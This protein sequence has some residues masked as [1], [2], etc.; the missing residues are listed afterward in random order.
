MDSE[1]A[2]QSA[3]SLQTEIQYLRRPS[4][5]A[6]A[7][8]MCACGPTGR[9]RGHRPVEVSGVQNI[10]QSAELGIFLHASG[11]RSGYLGLE[12]EIR[13]MADHA[14]CNIRAKGYAC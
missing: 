14:C 10:L 13:L 1:G 11:N 12:T 3:I 6:A 7:S 4:R 9:K 2:E 5:A 8:S